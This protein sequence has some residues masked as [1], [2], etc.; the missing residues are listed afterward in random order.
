[1]LG[2]EQMPNSDD[3]LS[4]INSIYDVHVS[5]YRETADRIILQYLE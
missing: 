1:M 2:I 3:H 5:I 4:T